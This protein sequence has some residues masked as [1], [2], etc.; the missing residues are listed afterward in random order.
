MLWLKKSNESGYLLTLVFVRVAG[1]FTHE[2]FTSA[3]HETIAVEESLVITAPDAIDEQ[4]I[5]PHYT[6]L[7]SERRLSSDVVEVEK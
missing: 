6:I 7:V 4:P 3:F 2:P 1:N 5:S